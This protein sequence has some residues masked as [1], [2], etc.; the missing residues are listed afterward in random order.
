MSCFPPPL[1]LVDWLDRGEFGSIT[2]NPE[3]VLNGENSMLSN[4]QLFSVMLK[5]ALTKLDLNSVEQ[6]YY[7]FYKARGLLPRTVA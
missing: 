7:Q 5:T 6:I 4:I 3:F 2:I 1:E